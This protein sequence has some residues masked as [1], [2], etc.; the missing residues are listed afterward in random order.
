[1]KSL[2]STAEQEEN[3][4]TMEASAPQDHG[5]TSDRRE[6]AMGKDVEQLPPGYFRSVRFIGSYCVSHHAGHVS[7]T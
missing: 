4:A 7:G 2:A 6:Q 3:I 1:M 5:P